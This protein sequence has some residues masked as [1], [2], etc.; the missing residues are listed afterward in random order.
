MATAK[1]KEGA[2]R[3]GWPRRNTSLRA[4]AGVP[5]RHP[6]WPTA[7]SNAVA[8]YF[9]QRDVGLLSPHPGEYSALLL[10]QHTPFG[11]TSWQAAP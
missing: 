1:P 3:F 2:A 10:M 5:A 8:H 4:S 9:L 7:S 11:Y 6:A